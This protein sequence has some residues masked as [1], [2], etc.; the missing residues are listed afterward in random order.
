MVCLLPTSLWLRVGMHHM[1]RPTWAALCRPKDCRGIRFRHTRGTPR[2]P[3]TRGTPTGAAGMGRQRTRH[4]EKGRG[5]ASTSS[6]P[7]ARHPSRWQPLGRMGLWGANGGSLLKDFARLRGSHGL[8]WVGA[9][10]GLGF[11]S[12]QPFLPHGRLGSQRPAA[13][14]TRARAERRLLNSLQRF[15][16][17]AARHVRMR[18]CVPCGGKGSLPTLG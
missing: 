7:L 3:R 15:D 18:V 6:P 1:G 13:A 16:F 5:G 12:G 4:P 8:S 9:W 11:G 10:C 17:P 2:H 14:N